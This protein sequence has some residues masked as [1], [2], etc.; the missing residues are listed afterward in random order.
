MLDQNDLEVLQNMMEN[1]V[2][3]KIAESENLLLEKMDRMQTNLSNRIDKID[4]RL[5]SMQHDV[6]T[7]RL[8]AGTLDLLLKRIDRLESQVE[9]LRARI[10]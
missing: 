8:E 5:D 6:N 10:E 4:Q 2:G 1:V 3:S 9:E 7:C